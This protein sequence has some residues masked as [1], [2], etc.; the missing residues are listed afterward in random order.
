MD[1]HRY[2]ASLQPLAIRL[3]LERMERALDA[4]GRPDRALRVLHVA[5]TN[6]KGSTCAM[7]AAAL[8]AAGHRTGLYTS[9]HLVR[10]NERIAVDGAPVDDAALARLVGEVRRACPWHEAGGEGERLTYF[11]FATA[12]A[13]LHFAEQGLGAAV[14]EVGLGGR[15]DATNAVRPL[16]CAVSRIGLDHTAL[17]GETLDAIAR[18]K[19]G[20]FKAGVPAVVAHDQPPEAL[21]ALRAE[22]A[23]RGAPL[24]VAAAGYPGPLAL[25]GPHQ[26]ANAA[27]AAAALR[28]LD[29]AGLPVPEE[30]IARG[31]AT[32]RW[33]GRLETVGGVLLDGA[34]NP[35]GAAA[36]AAA[37]PVLHPGRPVELVFG[38]LAD[39][40][41][42]RILHALAPAVR[43]LHLVAPRSPRARAP[44]TY[45]DL[46]ARLVARVDAHASAAEAIACARR[47]AADG[48][49]VC[50]AGSLYL[51]GEARGLLAG[52]PAAA[53]PG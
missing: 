43:A 25:A 44:D 15:F 41:H 29:G 31:L 18:E 21:A 50:V 7:A 45:R 1:P 13:L 12:L 47:A 53:D 23:R 20:I 16:A 24:A 32:A 38:V 37:L 9:P 40:D 49:V 28:L 46:A 26:Q 14:L 8:Q 2:L 42:A 5:G 19:G 10:F 17:L 22:A 48:A 6:G 27:L 33:P 39:K 3:G 30:A 4:L 34:H 36:L 51:V 52:E 35:D 11:E